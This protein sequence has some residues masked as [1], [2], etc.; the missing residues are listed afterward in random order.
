MQC[1]PG[2]FKLSYDTSVDSEPVVLWE[3]LGMGAFCNTSTR[4]QMPW[5]LTD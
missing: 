2:C 3:V 4:I 5:H 1:R